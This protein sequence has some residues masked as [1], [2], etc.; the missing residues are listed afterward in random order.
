MPV[1]ERGGLHPRLECRL[2]PPPGHH[3]PGGTPVGRL[4][5]LEA[6]EAVL[7]IHRAGPGG[8]PAGELVAAVGGPRYRVDPPKRHAPDP[9]R[10]PREPATRADPGGNRQAPGR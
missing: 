5:Q 8:E 10:P 1:P 7:V 2:V 4:E 6:L 3:E 9:A